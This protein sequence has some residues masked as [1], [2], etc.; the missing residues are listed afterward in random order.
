MDQPRGLHLHALP[1]ELLHQI[2]SDLLG[3]APAKSLKNGPG[4][5]DFR[6]ASRH[7][8]RIA[9]PI[10]SQFYFHERTLPLREDKIQ[11]FAANMTQHTFFRDSVRALTID[12]P[13]VDTPNYPVQ[14]DKDLLPVGNPEVSQ[15][16]AHMSSLLSHVLETLPSL[17]TI[18][19][20]GNPQ[21]KNILRHGREWRYLEDVERALRVRE[22]LGTYTTAIIHDIMLILSRTGIHLTRLCI[23]TPP[24]LR[25]SALSRNANQG[26]SRNPPFSL[27]RPVQIDE[28]Q[29]HGFR[30][31]G[32][33]GLW[34]VWDER[35]DG[36]AS[37]IVQF[38][39]IFSGIRAMSISFAR[40][41]AL[42]GITL[43]R[44]HVCERQFVRKLSTALRLP[45]LDTLKLTHNICDERDLFALLQAHATTLKD[46]HLIDIWLMDGSWKH[47]FLNVYDELPG[48]T[49]LV[50]EDC[51]GPEGG[52]VCFR[53]LGP[54]GFT[55]WDGD[56]EKIGSFD[57]KFHV[58]GGHT[59]ED[60]EG[61]Q[62]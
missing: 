14:L 31:P 20:R 28:L 61:L 11:S 53:N 48:I 51:I 62:C 40:S 24:L 17:D 16:V 39:H 22:V 19:L 10:I 27:P 43:L 21:L 9:L 8:N 44:Q 33:G 15:F 32:T 25:I 60:I 57:F 58:A 45:T 7:L 55:E 34:S 46:V 23:V 1:D 38:T 26:E 12:F 47:F 4:F 36:G 59:R 18:T 49:S 2:I 30:P 56:G 29:L 6:L 35:E 13:S 3:H 5:L 50:A 41:D 54:G 37:H 52:M 42:P